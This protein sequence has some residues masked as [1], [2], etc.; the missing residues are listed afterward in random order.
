MILLVLSLSLLLVI[1]LFNVVLGASF[2]DYNVSGSFGATFGIDSLTGALSVIIILITVATIV[3]IQVLGSG[4]SEQSVRTIIIVVGYAGIW[5]LFSVLAINLI[6]S[7]ELFGLL[8]YL[9]LTILYAIGVMD[10]ISN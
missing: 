6:L 2:S 8:I 3:G 4:I 1:V 9:L 10:K 7:I 5:G